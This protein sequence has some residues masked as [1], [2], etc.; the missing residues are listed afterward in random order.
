MSDQSARKHPIPRWAWIFAA[1]CFV[2]PIL[3]LGGAIP[4]AIGG[5]SGFA[6]IAIAR[7]AGK[8][9]RKKLI[10]CGVVTGS[11]WTV[12]VVF[13]LALTALQAKY[14]SL[15]TK[16]PKSEKP[17]TPPSAAG[18][19]EPGSESQPKQAAM[20]DEQRREIYKVAVRTR[21]HIEFAKEQRSKQKAKGSDVSARDRQIKRLEQMHQDHLDFV[22]R[23][24]KISR[25][26][27]DVLV[28]E[29]DRNN[30]PAD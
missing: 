24:H 14:P 20:T 27:L 23:F 4:G 30:W 11:A 3:T 19:V 22:A 7:Q 28:A 15:D 5:F 17:D 25:D 9:T 12:F 10:H 29:G 16:R 2:I 1:A 8:P 6:V 13:L 26:R 21:Y 18:M